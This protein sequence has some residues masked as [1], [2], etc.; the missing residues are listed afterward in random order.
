MD[1]VLNSTLEWAE[2]ETKRGGGGVMVVMF[3]DH[4]QTGIQ[5]LTLIRT[6]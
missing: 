2:A 4:G 5:P 3:G 1:R 6:P